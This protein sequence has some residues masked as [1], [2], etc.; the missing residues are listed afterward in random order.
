MT[1]PL[2]MPPVFSPPVRWTLRVLAWLAFALAAY[3]AWHAVTNSSVA[4]CS[5]GGENGCD[6]VLGSKW[7]LWIS[8][9]IPV[10]VLGLACYAMLASL[11][12][13]LGLENRA[14]RWITTAFVMFAIL[15]ACASLWFIGL[16]IFVIGHFCQ[17]CIV[18]D[19]LGIALG[20]LS[21]FFFVRWLND[22]EYLRRAPL[23]QSGVSA[24][25][26]ALP[27]VPRSVL[28]LGPH[29]APRVAVAPA[30]SPSLAVAAVGAALLFAVLVGGQLLFPVAT[31]DVQKIALSDS[32][33]MD[34]K[35]SA[36]LIGPSANV[37]ERVAM[38]IPTAESE[39]DDSQTDGN[40][41]SEAPAEINESNGQEN[42]SAADETTPSPTPETERSA[43]EKS[44]TPAA[45][46][47]ETNAEP[48]PPKKSRLVK[49][50][51]GK[52][53]LDTYKHPIIG[54]PEA[55]HIVVELISYDCP[56]CRKMSPI[57]DQAR[58]R[59][60]DQVAILVLTV[61]LEQKCNKLLTSTAAS[62]PGACATAQLAIGLAKLKPSSFPKFHDFLMS[63]D[64]EK[65]P[66]VNKIIPKAYAMADSSKLREL[67]RSPEMAKQIEFYVN[68]FDKLSKQ[69]SGNKSFGL[70]VQ[71]LGDHVMSGSVEKSEDVFNAW[72]KNLGVKPK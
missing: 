22:T 16:Q 13:L 23:T 27:G 11:S 21:T 39:H 9:S 10:A 57:V 3:L 29:A 18:T 44:A 28:P 19:I 7:S 69:N 34:E 51:G 58:A 60:G 40:S 35:P 1:A 47:S 50:L 66:G 33:S 12:V 41:S 55:P 71:I 6:A 43:A 17:Y 42:N 46:A 45:V 72:E 52:L 59:Y 62:H 14:T 54:S 53:T 64:K 8:R 56:H 36:N 61:P 38:R 24:L 65:P 68:L 48:E 70:P 67:G 49:F 20:A 2:T 26:A 32:M 30:K 63:G 5:V 25:R 37:K 15:A 31:F 4:G